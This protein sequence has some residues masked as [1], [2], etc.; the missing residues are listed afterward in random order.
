MY[1][2]KLAWRFSFFDRF[3]KCA[4][5]FPGRRWLAGRLAKAWCKHSTRFTLMPGVM[6]S[7]TKTCAFGCTQSQF[8]SKHFARHFFY[9]QN[10]RLR[11]HSVTAFIS[12]LI[13]NGAMN[14]LKPPLHHKTCQP[15]RQPLKTPTSGFLNRWQKKMFAQI[16]F[17]HCVTQKPFLCC[18]GF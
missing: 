3:I 17:T 2:F 13:K 1:S 7:S 6:F 10:L 12:W 18:T 8:Y 11:M 4:T 15:L 14:L 9:N 16:Y 5:L